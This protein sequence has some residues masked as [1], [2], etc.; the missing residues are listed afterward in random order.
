MLKDYTLLKKIRPEIHKR[1]KNAKSRLMFSTTKYFFVA[2]RLDLSDFSVT[3][4]QGNWYQVHCPDQG[5]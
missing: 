2:L 5:G 3:S 4:F 1:E